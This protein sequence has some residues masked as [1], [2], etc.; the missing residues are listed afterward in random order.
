[1]TYSYFDNGSGTLFAILPAAATTIE[2]HALFIEK[3][4]QLGNVLHIEDGY[5]GITRS[6]QNKNLKEYNARSFL[7]NFHELIQSIPHTKL[8][9]IGESVGAL[10]SVNFAL[11]Y[12][13]EVATLFL[14]SPALYKNS[15]INNLIYLI[16]VNITLSTLPNVSFKLITSIFKRLP[17][18]RL[19]ALA[20]TMSYVSKRTNPTTYALC[21]KE[22]LLFTQ[23][24]Q[25]DIFK[26]LG[27]KSVVLTGEHDQLFR[28]LCDEKLC[29]RAKKMMI[30]DDGW[31]N[32]S[33]RQSE[34]IAG[35]IE[36]ALQEG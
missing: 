4:R 33:R 24:R 22:I 32:L 2:D 9:L 26:I 3:L 12:N 10:H 16:L 8:I 14:L 30:V 1:M 34:K 27:K 25:N 31:H 20:E 21:L 17:S 18:K 19:K 11:K 28:F 7:N 23:D 29:H 5:F 6:I 35:I 13:E 36:I 15:R